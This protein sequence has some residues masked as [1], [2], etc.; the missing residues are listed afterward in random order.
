[1]E[2]LYLIYD[3]VAD[4]YAP[5]FQAKN[6][7]VACRACASALLNVH[8]VRDYQLVKVGTIEDFRVTP[9]PEDEYGFI[10]FYPTYDAM[11]SQHIQSLRITEVEGKPVG[12]RK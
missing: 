10:D 8:D 2:N 7:A 12:G 6:D 1:M 3:K 9:I 4:S 5:V 11:L